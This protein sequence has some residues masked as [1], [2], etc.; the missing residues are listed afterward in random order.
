MDVQCLS[1]LFPDAPAWT[2][3]HRPCLRRGCHSLPPDELVYKEALGV[4]PDCS[5][6]FRFVCQALLADCRICYPFREWGVLTGDMPRDDQCSRGC[7]DGA[8]VTLIRFWHP[9]DVRR[10][11][12][13]G[14]MRYCQPGCYWVPRAVCRRHGF[15]GSSCRTA[16]MCSVYSWA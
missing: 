14:F 16:V 3:G 12:K 2:I 4:A 10:G 15:I 5:I 7:S 6:E 9:L 1:V 8:K 13:C 11:E